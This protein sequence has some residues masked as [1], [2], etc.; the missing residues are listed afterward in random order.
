MRRLNGAEWSFD[1]ALITEA[2]CL[3]SAEF[4]RASA[5]EYSPTEP[6]FSKVVNA[7][8]MFTLF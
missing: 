5:R 8:L 6:S 7:N 4:R 2:L 3:S 1:E